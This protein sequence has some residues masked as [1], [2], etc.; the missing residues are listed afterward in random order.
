[1]PSKNLET[2]VAT[3]KCESKRAT[4]NEPHDTE[5]PKEQLEMSHERKKEEW[6]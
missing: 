6:R 2:F 4:R 3:K 1:M 5:N